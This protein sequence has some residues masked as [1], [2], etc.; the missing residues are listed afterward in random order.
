MANTFANGDKCISFSAVFCP[1]MC[2]CR[3]LHMAPIASR[4]VLLSSFSVR[5]LFNCLNFKNLNL[6][7]ISRTFF[8]G[9]TMV[10]VAVHAF[11]NG[12]L[13]IFD[14]VIAATL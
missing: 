9:G 4:F 1:K 5:E 10:A 2:K 7:L 13:A 3:L 11:R 14:F 8:A 6:F 12:D